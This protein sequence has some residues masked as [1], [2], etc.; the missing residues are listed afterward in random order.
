MPD[1]ITDATGKPLM[2]EE[3]QLVETLNGL[4]LTGPQKQRIFDSRN[5]ERTLPQILRTLKGTLDDQQIQSIW[6]RRFKTYAPTPTTGIPGLPGVLPPA[7]EPPE[8][9]PARDF[10]TRAVDF[11]S[12]TIGNL[13]LVRAARG[14]AGQ[15]IS[16]LP[17]FL[18]RTGKAAGRM[19]QGISN[20]AAAFAERTA[21]EA[22]DQ[23]TGR[24][25]TSYERPLFELERLLPSREEEGA[26]PAGQFGVG[27]AEVASGLTSPE[28]LVTLLGMKSLPAGLGRVVSG[29][30]A[31][32]MGQGML[33]EV[34]GLREAVGRQDWPEASRI[35]GRALAQGVMS[36]AAGKHALRGGALP[37]PAGETLTINEPPELKRLTGPTQMPARR[38]GPGERFPGAGK[39]GAQYV[40]QPPQL[41]GGLRALPEPLPP[42]V[43]TYPPLLARPEGRGTQPLREPAIQPGAEGT[44][45]EMGAPAGVPEPRRVF[46]MGNA[47]VVPGT[48]SR[49]GPV[50]TELPPLPPLPSPYLFGG[51]EGARGGLEAPPAARTSPPPSVAPEDLPVPPATTQ[52]QRRVDRA[53]AKL[54]QVTETFQRKKPDV[55]LDEFWDIPAWKKARL[56]VDRAR[57]ALTKAQAAAEMRRRILGADRSGAVGLAQKKTALEPLPPREPAGPVAT[58][59]EATV[60]VPGESTHYPVVYA[61][62]ELR[63]VQP[64][65]NPATFEPNPAYQYENRRYYNDPRNQ[66]RVLDYTRRFDP[67]FVLMDSPTAEHGAPI[68]DASGNVLGGNSRAMTIARIMDQRPEAAEQYKAE[69]VARAPAYGL[70]PQQVA[71]MERPVL[72]RQAAGQVDA[73]RAIADFNKRGAADYTEAERAMAGAGRISPDTYAL[74]SAKLDAAGSMA[75]ALSGSDGVAVLDGL[76]RDGAI[77]LPEKGGMLNERAELTVEA[78]NRIGKALL[79]NFFRNPD[80]FDRTSP[81]VRGKL[82][83]ALGPAIRSAGRPDW[84]LI[85]KS[86]AALD[87]LEEAKVRGSQDL[88][89]LQQQRDLM[90]GQPRYDSQAIELARVLRDE[91]TA[92]IGEAFRQYATDEELSR[93]GMPATFAVP[94]SQEQAFREAFS[95]EGF[96]ER[97]EARKQGKQQREII[98][99]GL[100]AEEQPRDRVRSLPEVYAN[101]QGNYKGRRPGQTGSLYLNADAAQVVADLARQGRQFSGLYVPPEEVAFVHDRLRRAAERAPGVIGEPGAAA[102][103][104]LTEQ[105]GQAAADGSGVTIVVK[106]PGI[107]ATKMTARH[108]LAHRVAAQTGMFTEINTIGILAADPIAATAR[109]AL[110]ARYGDNA[111]LLVE[112]MFAR[113]TAGPGRW[114]EMGISDPEGMALLETILR[115]TIGAYGPERS[116][117]IAS[118][119]R[120]SPTVE[121]IFRRAFGEPWPP[122][123]GVDTAGASERRTTDGGVPG[124]GPRGI[125]EGLSGPEGGGRRGGRRNGGE[126]AGLRTDR[127]LRTP[128]AGRG[129]RGT[130]EEAGGPGPRP[131]FLETLKKIADDRAGF[132][133]L[134]RV[135]ELLRGFTRQREIPAGERRYVIDDGPI[136]RDVNP[137]LTWFRSPSQE[138]H[139]VYDRAGEAVNAAIKAAQLKDRNM[140]RSE[141]SA[142][143]AF[144][145]LPQNLRERLVDM[146]D[147]PTITPDQR[148]AGVPD[149][150]WQS[151]NEVRGLLESTRK[152]MI[153]ARRAA[154][155]TTPED[156]GRTRGY[157]PHVFRGDW[158]VMVDGKPAIVEGGWLGTFEESV[159]KAEAHLKDNPDLA[160][161]ITLKLLEP[162]FGIDDRVQLNRGAIRKLARGIENESPFDLEDAYEMVYGVARPGAPRRYFGHAQTRQANLPAFLKSEA[163]LQT[164]IRGA[165]RYIQMAPLRTMMERT[166]D[167]LDAAHTRGEI[168]SILPWRFRRWIDAV[169]GRPGI[170][171]RGVMEYMRRFYPRMSYEKVA[172]TASILTSAEALLKLGFSPITALV[173]LTQFPINAWPV[174]GTKYSL[175]GMDAFLRGK[176][177]EVLDELGIREQ[178]TKAEEMPGGQL[179]DVA[180]SAWQ[181]LRHKGMAGEDF[182]DFLRIYF[183]ES[184]GEIPKWAAREFTNTGLWMFMQSEYA[185]RAPAALGAY[186]RAREALGQSHEQAV[187]T[188]RRTVTRTMFSYN[189]A[190]APYI[191][192][193]PVLAPVSQF[194]RYLVKQMEFAIGLGQ[195]GTEARFDTRKQELGRFLLAIG[196]V[197]GV[198]GLPG[199]EA[200]DSIIEALTGERPID[201]LA[202]EHPRA[203]RGAPAFFPGWDLHSNIG[204]SEWLSARALSGPQLAGPLLSDVMRFKD[205]FFGTKPGTREHEDAM[206]SLWRGVSPEFRRLYDVF[207]EEAQQGKLIDFKGNV[208]LKDLTPKERLEFALGVT[209]LR[210]AHERQVYTEGLREDRLRKSERSVYVEK[211][212]ALTQQRRYKE[213]Y[214]LMDE[215]QAKG[216]ANL[217]DSLRSYDRIQDLERLERLRAR[218]PK[219]ERE[220]LPPLP[221]QEMFQKQ[222]GEEQ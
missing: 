50:R 128:G 25:P 64:S 182:R 206:Q 155:I 35:G 185:V 34:P 109:K 53:V 31:T 154:G 141:F 148:P 200:L 85:P 138:W 11:A 123:Q 142:R 3:S 16:E 63:D 26:G 33:Q 151:Y 95:R 32:E 218:T 97:R 161:K 18:T 24:K 215:A 175:K 162:R 133:N 173:N 207:R 23:A 107:S 83:R 159:K 7:G 131:I 139:K 190:D 30:F 36:Y 134:D 49:P 220:K 198:K 125:P 127:D 103:R 43:I 48:E 212:H 68:I 214:K 169:E 28:G 201:A 77:S 183:P 80:Q 38:V 170:V 135:E 84:S 213:A 158:A 75:D 58:G 146:L 178:A 73:P 27:V 119:F 192:A 122:E 72:V 99:D 179:G 101:A 15:M 6:D 189:V 180:R 79:G 88:T 219:H 156:W 167:D 196:L 132:L 121:P 150:M 74:V 98:V 195:K 157:W 177:P 21:D 144:R 222:L 8:K 39:E 143:V 46:Y 61:V 93:P 205:A 14:E 140:R 87:A 202:A 4:P 91:P 137:I 126:D 100:R 181:S 193:S 12:T 65:H 117:T 57:N 145:R 188:A 55:P 110:R 62:R 120:R 153:G 89:V 203:T 105:L 42:P 76:I 160:G 102:L 9:L 66:E 116:R 165:E 209:P 17:E 52:A 163:G 221:T 168:G 71:A 114:G 217:G 204:F 174:L 54:R 210:V 82:E 199:S 184:P 136:T 111:D 115:D 22:I 78:K 191:L 5:D 104:D 171:S 45:Y 197:A 60:K 164:Y 59:R 112:E 29:F 194:K 20:P 37:Q 19:V 152:R 113:L 56:E 129:P 47:E 124:R 70:D 208:I 86:Q 149:K 94:P 166:A 90:T 2:L 211:I 147:D 51:E 118:Q 106:Q 69:L 92:D 10:M 13:P 67:D 172:N 96:R 41:E 130:A 81:E 108:E 216:H 186:L 1:E 187:E 44:V 40:E 176:H